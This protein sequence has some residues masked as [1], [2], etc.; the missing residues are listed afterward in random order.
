MTLISLADAMDQHYPG[1]SRWT[2]VMDENNVRL[3]QKE[4]LALSLIAIMGKGKLLE[5]IKTAYLL[6]RWVEE[7]DG[8]D[9]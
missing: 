3:T 7:E 8:R 4:A 9:G 5:A 2:Q 1:F 6:G